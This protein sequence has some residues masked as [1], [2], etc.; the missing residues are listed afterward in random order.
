MNDKKFLKWESLV[1]TWNFVGPP[2][3]PSK[4]DIN[5]YGQFIM[6][7]IAERKTNTA[8]ALLLGCTPSLR[9]LMAN[10]D[11]FVTCVDVNP[12]MI[13]STTSLIGEKA[14]GES[15]ICQ[16]WLEM[17]LEHKYSVIIGDKVLDNI[18][19]EKWGIFKEKLLTHLVTG[20]SLIIRIAPQDP[21]LLG[22]SF[23][24]LLM[25]WTKQYELGQV[26]LKNAASGL[27]EQA[28]GASAKTVPGKQSIS[29]FINEIN[30]LQKN[31]NQLSMASQDILCQFEKMFSQSLEH[32]WTSYSFDDIIDLLNDE[33]V[34]VS[35]KN[36]NDYKVA[37]RQPI[38]LFKKVT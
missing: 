6:S 38:L 30:E 5:I 12:N 36:A 3:S 9:L 37:K 20:G 28:L 26:S 31:I 8:T 32:E 16:D 11:I 7:S 22:K 34:L 13:A 14:N 17:E 33:F 10:M 18:P 2:A 27:W 25:Y 29:L 21:L 1:N 35:K 19:H 4:V 23:T 15:Y 24:D